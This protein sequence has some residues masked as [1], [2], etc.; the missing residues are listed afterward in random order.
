MSRNCYRP[1]I[2]YDHISL[3]SCLFYSAQKRFE[4]ICKNFCFSKM[5]ILVRAQIAFQMVT[6]HKY[7]LMKQ[8]GVKLMFTS[9]PYIYFPLPT[10]WTFPQNHGLQTWQTQDDLMKE[11]GVKLIFTSHLHIYFPFDNK[12]NLFSDTWFT[13]CS[14]ESEKRMPSVCKKSAKELQKTWD[15]N[16]LCA[17]YLHAISIEPLASGMAMWWITSTGLLL[18]FIL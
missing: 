12:I 14:M 13:D 3:V 2:F 8:R 7:N 10:K 1:S 9:D 4:V 17:E 6:L 5:N 15:W 16:M 18:P 11:R